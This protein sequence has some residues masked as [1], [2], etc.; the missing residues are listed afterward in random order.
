MTNLAIIELYKATHGIEEELHT[1]ARWKALGFSVKKGEHSKH[2]IS[3]WKGWETTKEDPET[4]E[5][6]TRSGVK[7][8]EACFFLASQVEPEKERRGRK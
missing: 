4:G 3:I 2:R 7:M 6:K 1:F 8:K 5:E